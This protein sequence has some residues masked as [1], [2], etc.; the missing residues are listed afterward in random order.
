MKNSLKTTWKH[1]RSKHWHQLDHVLANHLA[2]QHV[3][4]VRVNVSADCF[5]DHRLLV[6]KCS[7]SLKR[8]KKG[9]KPP[10]RPS[11]KVTPEIIDR[12]QQYFDQYLTNLPQEW[13]DLKECL[14]NAATFVFGKKR[15][16]Q[17]DWF[18]EN[19]V[20]I[21]A[22]IKDR[23]QNKK[24]IQ[25]HVRQIKNDWFVNKA[26][27]AEM[28]YNQNNLR[29]FYSILR[30]VYGPRTKSTHQ[31]RSKNGTLLTT[32][33]EIS[34]RWIEH[35]SDLLNIETDVDMEVLNEIEQ[36]PV[37]ESLAEPFTEEE[38]DKAIKNMKPGKSP[39]PDGILP[40]TIKYGGN[41]LKNYLLTFFN[42]FWI[43]E[44]LPSDLVN[45][46][47]N[48]TILFK[49]GDRSQCGNF[50]GISLLSVVGKFLADMILQRLT[51]LAR[52][53]YPESQ[54]GYREGR[55]TIDGIFTVRQLME[56]SREQHRNLYIAFIDFTKAFDT[57]NRQL[58]FSILEKIGCPPKLTNLIKLLYTNVKARLI[59]DGELS[60]L[61]KYN[62]GVKQGCKLAPT[63]FGIYAA[64]LLLVAFKDIKHRR[65]ILIR[66]RTDGKFFDLRRLKAKSKVMHEFIREAQ[67]ADDIAVMSDSSEG[68]Q[69]LL[70]AY[71]AAAKRFGLRINA[72]KTEVMCMG[73]E[74]IFFVDEIPL[75]NVD[76]FK[77][78]GS[79]VTKDCKLQ[80]EL[81]SRIQATS[82]AFGRL[83]HRVFDNRDL[84]IS[85]KIA[86]YKQC[87]LPIL[88]YGSE[89][90]T[91]Y[92][93][94]IRQLRTFQQRHLRSIMKIK[95][96]DYVSNE[97]VL[98][99]A[100][101]DDIEILLA[102]SR[103]R[104]LGHVGRMEDVR[105]AKLICLVNSNMVCALLGDQN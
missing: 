2:R 36:M 54:Q 82:S 26:N 98:S 70:D 96:D 8:K 97:Q 94:E 62:S 58:L 25:R 12:L 22:L 44:L 39:G 9:R 34:D 105:A 30:E 17:N 37:D 33:K 53:V 41:A 42:L 57:V 95:W 72:G 83:R 91:L 24:E 85:T 32:D 38:F 48:I 64:V 104:W 65:S 80:V 92:S 7:F 56:K 84:T 23:H 87:L 68:L 31:I 75:K 3:D 63:L 11:I 71:N 29:E 43:T 100:N 60:K 35:F 81:T 74:V 66:F 27:Q 13:D 1:L 16:H 61:F 47:P 99:R 4:V 86:V 19:D 102:K 18:D 101:I 89:T 51:T 79:F 73:P 40:E 59:V 78:L 46:N 6:C 10:S 77:Y 103:L 45:P 49:K 55:G 28:F 15:K 52:R 90:W 69:E 5:T 88:L 14:Q 50:R 67:Y 21:Y 93:Y 20:E 76:R